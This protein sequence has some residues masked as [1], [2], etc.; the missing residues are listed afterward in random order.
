MKQ[1]FIIH[2]NHPKL[3]LFFAGWAAD[4]TLFK[5]YCPKGSDYMICYDYRT[6]DFDTS[7]LNNYQHVNVVAWSMG[8]WVATIALSSV[9]HD[10]LFS[11]AF[12]GSTFPIDECEGIPPTTFQATLDGLT[13]ATLQKFMR[14]MCKDS[15]AYKDFL[16]ISPRRDFDEIKEELNL[17]KEQHI[18]LK[19][20]VIDEDNN[21]QIS[22][23]EFDRYED[24]YNYDYDF[25]FIGKHDRIFPPRNLAQ[26]FDNL[27][28]E[29]V[30]FADCAHYDEP[31]FR[32]LLQDMWAMPVDEFLRHLEDLNIREE[33]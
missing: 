20:I 30:I 22:D 26:N 10:K 4:E 11:I 31:M 3:L 21:Y 15:N 8:V 16:K 18:K 14:R 25:A 33:D 17:I 19:G 2:E 5:Q 9:P 12:N 7:L 32:F 1:V 23:E 6:L 13:P 28:Y 24:A 29:R 27:E